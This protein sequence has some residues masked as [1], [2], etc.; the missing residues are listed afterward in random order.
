[1]SNSPKHL[2]NCLQKAETSIVLII[3]NG[4]LYHIDF[5]YTVT[6]F[7]LPSLYINQ[8]PVKLYHGHCPYTTTK[9]SSPFKLT[10]KNFVKAAAYIFYIKK[11][12]Y[13]YIV[14]IY[15]AVHKV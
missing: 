15:V 8:V 14:L 9:L 5:I 6:V 4:V 7:I 1:M 10:N 12:P 13:R 11:Q 2:P 3:F